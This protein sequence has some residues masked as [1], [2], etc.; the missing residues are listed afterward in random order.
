MAKK[1]L[2]ELAPKVGGAFRDLLV[3]AAS[4]PATA[5]LAVMTLTVITKELVTQGKREHQW[6]RDFNNEMG[7]LYDGAQKLALAAAVVPSVVGAIGSVAAAVAVKKGK[8][9]T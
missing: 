8:Q 3:A 7:G 4:H 6:Q 5:G 1:K 2:K 9:P